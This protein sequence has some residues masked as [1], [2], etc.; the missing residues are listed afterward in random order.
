MPRYDQANGKADANSTF[1]LASDSA[2]LADY[3]GTTAGRLFEQ[4]CL[5]SV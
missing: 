4:F 3:D 5:A 1:E 2:L